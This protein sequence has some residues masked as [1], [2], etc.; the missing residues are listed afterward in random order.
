MDFE[1]PAR[2]ISLLCAP[3]GMQMAAAVPTSSPKILCKEWAIAWP[4]VV[5]QFP[6][7]TSCPQ[8]G[9]LV[10][11]SLCCHAS[12]SALTIAVESD[13]TFRL[14]HKIIRSSASLGQCCL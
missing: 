11:G 12:L 6:L 13:H 10:Y 3:N 8:I 1:N 9:R 2:Q 7:S 4:W 5:R 14:I